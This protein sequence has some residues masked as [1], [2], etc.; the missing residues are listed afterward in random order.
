MSEPEQKKKKKKKREGKLPNT[1]LPIE[2][3]DKKGWTEKWTK[4]RN[5]LNFPHSWRGVF[6]GLPSCG[7]SCTIKNIILRA[8]PPFEQIMVVHY[9]A[10]GTTEW[11]DIGGEIL[12][13]IPD[14]LEIESEGKKILILED[15]DLSSLNKIDLGRLNRLYGYCSSHKNL[16][17]ALTCQNAFDCPPCARR[18]SNLFVLWKQPD[19]CA[20]TTL[21]SRTGMKSKDFLEIFDK[22][23]QHEH[24]SLWIDL[25][26][27]SPAKLRIDG[28][29]VLKTN[30][31]E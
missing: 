11:D 8:K 22:F 12:D 26:K 1:I 20:M 16:S 23:I 7:K 21:A 13:E 17:L 2:S 31:E 15:L 28:Y 6:C 4:N 25:T 18:V 30:N 10:S 19:I 9:D 24:G 3:A 29:K 27:A 14:P 5:L